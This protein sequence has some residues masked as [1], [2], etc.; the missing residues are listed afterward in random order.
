MDHQATAAWSMTAA[1]RPA[2]AAMRVV[3]W[4]GADAL[5]SRDPLAVVESTVGAISAGGRHTCALDDGGALYCWVRTPMASWAT[6]RQLVVLR[7]YESPPTSASSRRAGDRYGCALSVDGRISCWGSNLA[8]EL[9]R[10]R[11]MPSRI[12]FLLRSPRMVRSASLRRDSQLRHRR[13]R[14]CWCWGAGSRRPPIGEAGFIAIAVGP[15]SACGV[16]A[17]GRIACW[18][19]PTG[20]S[21]AHTGPR[22]PFL[23][24]PPGPFCAEGR[25]EAI[26]EGASASRIPAPKVVGSPRW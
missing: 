14:C 24:R 10:E 7:R 9:G 19:T 22:R 1:G 3:N 13:L 15:V 6:A 5:E 17:T 16:G 12:R 4:L 26:Q 2:G 8:G 21:S 18:A 20:C 11:G 25:G 23:G